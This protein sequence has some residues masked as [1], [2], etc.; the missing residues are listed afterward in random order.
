MTRCGGARQATGF[1]PGMRQRQQQPGEREGGGRLQPTQAWQQ[2]SRTQQGSSPAGGRRQP[3]GTA[4][5]R[6]QAPACGQPGQHH[7][8]QHLQHP[9]HH[10][11]RPAQQRAQP[12]AAGL[13][14]LVQRAVGLSEG[15]RK[16]MEN[17]GLPEP[18][19]KPFGTLVPLG[20]LAVAILLIPA[21]TAK[22]GALLGL[23]LLLGFIAGITYN[24]SKG[25]HPDCHCF[26]VVHSAPIGAGTLI[27]N[28]VFSAIALV[29]IVFGWGDAGVS[30]CDW[31]RSEAMGGFE[32]LVLIVGLLILVVVVAEAWFIVH[33]L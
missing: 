18:I 12:P 30:P 4:P 6:A 29:I 11:A 3:N 19:A 25:K 22:Y 9:H 24:L 7:A 28:G 32:W 8:G 2:A 5:Q 15:S 27:R 10:P 13:A 23:I 1:D 33:M 16:A 14:W 31:N 17:F 21:S 20:E 26:G